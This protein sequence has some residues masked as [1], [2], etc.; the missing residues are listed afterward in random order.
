MTNDHAALLTRFE[1]TDVDPA[2][3]GHRQHVQVAYGMFRKYDFLEACTKYANAIDKIATKAGAPDK[4]NITI[5]LAFLSLIAERI[6]KTKGC[7]SIEEFLALNEDLLSSNIL[8]RWYTREQLQSEFART[9]FLL[10]NQ[11]AQR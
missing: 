9:H 3:F 8:S 4:F 7:A 5:T 10:P 11:A 2:Q 6:H 1:A